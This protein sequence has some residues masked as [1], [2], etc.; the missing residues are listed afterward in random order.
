MKISVWPMNYESSIRICL[1]SEQ[2]VYTVA[3]PNKDVDRKV[4]HWREWIGK[5]VDE[6]VR[7]ALDGIRSD[8]V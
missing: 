3:C 6:E 5:I 7:K 2:C 8:E 1:D 4:A